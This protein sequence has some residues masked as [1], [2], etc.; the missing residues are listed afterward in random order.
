[1]RY[2]LILFTS[3]LIVSC[4]E[5]NELLNT[6][7]RAD[8]FEH[9]DEFYLY[10]GDF[11]LSQNWYSSPDSF[12]R[13]ECDDY[14]DHVRPSC[15][16]PIKIINN[17]FSFVDYYGVERGCAFLQNQ[18][19][20]NTYQKVLLNCFGE[21][22]THDSLYSVDLSG[23]M[24][25]I[26]ELPYKQYKYLLETSTND[27]LTYLEYSF[28]DIGNLS[29][30][31]KNLIEKHA[32]IERNLTLSSD[33]YR[34]LVWSDDIVI[35]DGSDG[36]IA[37]EVFGAVTCNILLQL[38]ID[39]SSVAGSIGKDITEND[40]TTITQNLC[41]SYD[42]IDSEGYSYH[43][44]WICEEFYHPNNVDFSKYIPRFFSNPQIWWEEQTI[45]IQ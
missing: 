21:D 34:W 16:I 10:D 44:V 4:S 41:I 35:N 39:C 13:S 17:Y 3:I 7:N 15:L 29:G 38:P 8:L 1:M 28:E 40:G 26:Q 25:L 14:V 30:R 24:L 45:T 20:P 2:I 19:L 42:V 31:T 33:D 27:S 32:V 5:K 37:G 18:D 12:K 11:Y 43:Y 36:E 23:N 9:N 22:G 6:E